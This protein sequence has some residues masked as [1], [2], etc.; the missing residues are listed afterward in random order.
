MSKDSRRRVGVVKPIESLDV[1]VQQ[2]IH[3]R[4][5]MSM[6]LHNNRNGSKAPGL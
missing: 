2:C 3:F 6:A 4:D 1:L 5:N